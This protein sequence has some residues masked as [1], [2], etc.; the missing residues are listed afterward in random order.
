MRRFI[1]F[2][3]IL[4]ASFFVFT[5]CDENGDVETITLEKTWKV[6]G[7]LAKSNDGPQENFVVIKNNSYKMGYG[8]KSIADQHGLT[9]YDNYIIE[10][11]SGTYKIEPS[12]TTSGKLIVTID[13]QRIEVLYSELTANSVKIT[14]PSDGDGQASQTILLEAYTQEMTVVTLQEFYNITGINEDST[15]TVEKAWRITHDIPEFKSSEVHKTWFI[16]LKNG[17]YT[18]GYWGKPIADK[19]GISGFD[20]YIIKELVGT[21]RIE[22]SSETTGKLTLTFDEHVMEM[23]YSELTAKSVKFTFENEG[24]PYEF[25]LEACKIEMTTVTEDTFYEHIEKNW[26]PNKA[27]VTKAWRI[28]HD[29]PEFKSSEGNR[30]WFVV[31]KNGVYTMG[32]GGKYIADQYELTGFDNYIIKE[33][34][35]TYKFR[36][37]SATAGK[38]IL[39]FDEHVME[40]N[41]YELTKNSVKLSFEN[42]GQP[43]VFI[44]EA[45]TTEMNIVTET[46]FYTALEQNID[47]GKLTVEKTWRITHDIPEFKSSEGHRTWFIILKNGI[48]TM[49]YGGKYIADQHGITGYDN[50]I[51]KELVGTYRIE[52]ATKTTGKLVLTFD[53]HVMEMKYLALKENSVKFTFENEGQPYEFILE[54]CTTEMTIVT[55]EEFYKLIGKGK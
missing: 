51:I 11:L 26:D 31:F 44:L 20:N 3:A 23:Y 15:V 4:A 25:I 10:E 9:G 6:R 48:Y 40:M 19:I 7:D 27:M 5:A 45:C 43:F 18:M 34:V 12:S 54:A 38:F 52:S 35:G 46:E 1:T 49:G 21:Y 13:N 36:P 32:Y 37:S 41:Y 47:A 28:T 16:V 33:L 8:A 14:T 2:V 17:I 29:I 50:Y 30:T 39:T 24:Q 42:E 55:E 53:E 22:S